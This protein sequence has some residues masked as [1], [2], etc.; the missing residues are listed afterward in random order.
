MFCDMVIFKWFVNQKIGLLQ[1]KLYNIN[2][3]VIKWYFKFSINIYT[4]KYYK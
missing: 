3:T 1:Y 2:I 4:N